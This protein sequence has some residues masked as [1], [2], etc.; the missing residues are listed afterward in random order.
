[1]TFE[2]SERGRS[3]GVEVVFRGRLMLQIPFWPPAAKFSGR[4]Q[5]SRLAKSAVVQYVTVFRL[6]LAKRVKH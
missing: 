3:Q 4:H 6:I 1:M 5:V 2:I